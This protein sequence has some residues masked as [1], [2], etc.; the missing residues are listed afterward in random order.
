[1]GTLMILRVSESREV[2]V[3]KTTTEG[4][5]TDPVSL[6]GV[7]PAGVRFTKPSWVSRHRETNTLLCRNTADYVLIPGKFVP[8]RSITASNRAV[9]HKNPS[10][11]FN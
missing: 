9:Q 4:D 6:V 7:T 3:N 5:P 11:Q 2:M 1:M 8:K 10:M